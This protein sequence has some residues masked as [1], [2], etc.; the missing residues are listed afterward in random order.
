MHYGVILFGDNSHKR[1]STFDITNEEQY[2]F[3]DE[4]DVVTDEYN[5]GYGSVNSGDT[6]PFVDIYKDVETFAKDWYGCIVLERDNGN[7]YGYYKNP[8]GIFDWYEFGGRWGNPLKLKSAIRFAD[9]LRRCEAT[10]ADDKPESKRADYACVCRKADLDIQ[11]MSNEV[12]RTI[13]TGYSR[14]VELCQ[15]LPVIKGRE[16]YRFYKDWLDQP[17]F[18]KLKDATI[19]MNQY[20]CLDYRLDLPI[21]SADAWNE[22]T[23]QAELFILPC[24][25]VITADDVLIKSDSYSTYTD[26]RKLVKE[27]L[28]AQ[29]D[30]MLISYLDV[31][32]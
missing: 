23:I 32:E 27:L 16:N 6:R 25:Y 5:T 24:F 13:L 22:I 1:L 29:P 12:R 10:D 17:I 31:H 20:T 19:S 7:S 11:G 14:I 26:Y 28:M 30:D 21:G 18:N 9:D 4:T 3:H 2:E 8:K 15:G